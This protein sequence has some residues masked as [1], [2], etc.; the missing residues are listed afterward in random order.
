MNGYVL[1]HGLGVAVIG[2]VLLVL[3]GVSGWC[4]YVAIRFQRPNLKTARTFEAACW[5]MGAALVAASLL[6]LCGGLAGLAAVSVW[7]VLA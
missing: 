2:A 5:Y 4:V 7:K 1:S 6:L 3:T